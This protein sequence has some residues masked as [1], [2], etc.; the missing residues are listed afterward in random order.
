MASPVNERKAA[1]DFSLESIEGGTWRF[2]EHRGKVVVVN[3]WATW[4]PPCRIETPGL[5]AFANDYVGRGVEFVG[6]TVDED[7]DA[8]RNF[9]EDYQITYPIL[10]QGFDPNV[11]GDGMALPTRFFMTRKDI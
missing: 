9:V 11:V 3:Y 8:V 1:L 7:I 4:C 10:N 6:V 2:S 5:V